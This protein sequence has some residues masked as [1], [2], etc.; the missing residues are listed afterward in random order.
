MEFLKVA[1]PN[2]M[3]L[4]RTLGIN[5]GR[6]EK[7]KEAAQA[8][9]TDPAMH[10]IPECAVKYQGIC[11]T[12][13]DAFLFGYWLR[14]YMDIFLISGQLSPDIDEIKILKAKKRTA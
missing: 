10:N 12:M 11:E 3:N 4:S 2:G 13:E 5:A 14:R 7:I 6:E 8:C 1:D 9:I